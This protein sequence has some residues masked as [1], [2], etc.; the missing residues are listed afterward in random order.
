MRTA[1]ECQQFAEDCR[2]AAAKMTHPQ[3]RERLQQMAAAWEM[4]AL[5][6]DGHDSKPK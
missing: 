3:D 4:L 6:R 1:A 2:R 5:E